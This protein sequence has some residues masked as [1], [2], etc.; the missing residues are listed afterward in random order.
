MESINETQKKQ[1]KHLH[2]AGAFSF[3][4]YLFTDSC[5]YLLQAFLQDL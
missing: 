3:S 2:S 1:K 5:V 4:V